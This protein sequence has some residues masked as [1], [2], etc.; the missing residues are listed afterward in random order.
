MIT[1]YFHSGKL[2]WKDWALRFIQIFS[3]DPCFHVGGQY[4]TEPLIIESTSKRGVDIRPLNHYH[5]L[6]CNNGRKISA[7]SCLAEIDEKAFW[8]WM[9][10][11]CDHK[12]DWWGVIGLGLAQ[13]RGADAKNKWVAKKDFW[14]SELFMRGLRLHALNVDA[15]D[16]IPD[17]GIVKPSHMK[18][19]KWI[20]FKYN[21]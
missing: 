6:I 3:D 14:C 10:S 4:K 17:N 9:L 8:A 11:Q 5:D 1:L 19:S 13:L 18:N 12:Y 15:F 16:D 20:S 2:S 21:L 7:Y